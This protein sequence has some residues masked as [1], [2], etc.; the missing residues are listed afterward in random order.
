MLRVMGKCGVEDRDTIV[1]AFYNS[2]SY[3]IRLLPQKEIC[4]FNFFLGGKPLYWSLTV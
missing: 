4:I 3:H 2:K 1:L